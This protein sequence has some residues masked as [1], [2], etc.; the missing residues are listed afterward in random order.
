[1]DDLSDDEVFEVWLRAPDLADD[2]PWILRHSLENFQEKRLMADETMLGYDPAP[3][4]P[5]PEP[6]AFPDPPL[7]LEESDSHSDTGSVPPDLPMDDQSR[8][9][10]TASVGIKSAK[11]I[12]ANILKMPYKAFTASKGAKTCQDMPAER[13]Q[14]EPLSV[15]DVVVPGDSWSHEPCYFISSPSLGVLLESARTVV[16]APSSSPRDPVCEEPHMVQPN[17]TFGDGREEVTTRPD[18]PKSVREELPSGDLHMFI[19]TPSLGVRLGAAG[20]ISESP[21]TLPQVLSPAVRHIFPSQLGMNVQIE[22]GSHSAEALER[23]SPNAPSDG[24]S[25]FVLNPSSDIRSGAS[26]RV[27]GVMEIPSE[28]DMIPDGQVPHSETKGDDA[29]TAS[30]EQDLENTTTDSAVSESR[31]VQDVNTP[32]QIMH[33]TE[34]NSLSQEMPTYSDASPM[35]PKSFE[36]SA[37]I[38]EGIPVSTAPD[39]RGDSGEMLSPTATEERPK[40]S[41]DDQEENPCCPREE[42]MLLEPTLTNEDV[43][44]KECNEPEGSK[45]SAAHQDTLSKQVRFSDWGQSFHLLSFTSHTKFRAV[46]CEEVTVHAPMSRNA[47][48]NS[49]ISDHAHTQPEE[50]ASSSCDDIGGPTRLSSPNSATWGTDAIN[51]SNAPDFTS[52]DENESHQEHSVE[53]LSLPGDCNVVA[54]E[55]VDSMNA[56]ESEPSAPSS[57]RQHE[58]LRWGNGRDEAPH[59]ANTVHCA[60]LAPDQHPSTPAEHPGKNNTSPAPGMDHDPR[61]G[62]GRGAKRP[63]CRK[64]RRVPVAAQGG[65]E[66][67][68]MYDSRVKATSSSASPPTPAGGHSAAIRARAGNRHPFTPGTRPASNESGHHHHHDKATTGADGGTSPGRSD[69]GGIGIGIG[70]YTGIDMGIGTD[71]SIDPGTDTARGGAEASSVSTGSNPDSASPHCRYGT[72]AGDADGASCALVSHVPCSTSKLL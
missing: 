17:L 15:P 56:P 40:S 64:V 61:P 6:S 48:D 50:A 68:A 22:A 46:R 7:H 67:V 9:S 3:V 53:H 70:T 39:V 21:V 25:T 16:D 29:E 11:S 37:P 42:L 54:V 24:Q 69:T 72:G 28:L 34:D 27:T 20:S 57:A 31:D 43:E 35:N 49:S 52:L 4:K 30:R 5:V 45:D 58:G 13:G 63:P 33:P 19:S 59:G 62:G 55:E 60:P 26:D 18:T 38:D 8:E 51:L 44:G 47:P 10:S 32:M 66:R 2:M 14:G 12:V 1:M 65:S 36:I 71:T 23:L 41:L